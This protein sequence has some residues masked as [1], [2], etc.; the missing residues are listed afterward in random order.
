MSPF[1]SSAGGAAA[2]ARP[3]ISSAAARAGRRRDI[4]RSFALKRVSVANL[5]LGH[6][7]ISYVVGAH[8]GGRA[9][10]QAGLGAGGE[11]ARRGD[12]A[13]VGGVLRGGKIG[14]RVVLL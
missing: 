8:P 3:A 6:F 1:E 12:V 7:Q 4:G 10:G 9:D 11:L 2:G 5:R 14:M 13:S